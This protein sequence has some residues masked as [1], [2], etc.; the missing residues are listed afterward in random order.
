MFFKPS[1]SKDNRSVNI[2]YYCIFVYWSVFLLLDS[3]LDDLFDKAIDMKSI[4][5]LLSG[6]AVFFASELIAKFVLEKK[7]KKVHMK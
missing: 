3:L 2:A 1:K 7:H 6:L 5:L 4:D